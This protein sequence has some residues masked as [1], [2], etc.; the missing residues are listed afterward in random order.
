[1]SANANDYPSE[2]LP[3]MTAEEMLKAGWKIGQDLE[4]KKLWYKPLTV[5]EFREFREQNP[6]TY[7]Y[8]YRGN[9]G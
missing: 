7:Q 8:I 2:R 4:G 5:E 6:S 3:G 1:M 9:D